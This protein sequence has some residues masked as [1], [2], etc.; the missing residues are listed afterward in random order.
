MA[1]V[2]PD[3][4]KIT[5][6]LRY[7]FKKNISNIKLSLE[8]LFVFFF[9]LICAMSLQSLRSVIVGTIIHAPVFSEIQVQLNVF[10]KCKIYIKINSFSLGFKK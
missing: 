7:V 6:R 10:F 3:H 5:F 8:N 1:C 9:F 4:K 2:L